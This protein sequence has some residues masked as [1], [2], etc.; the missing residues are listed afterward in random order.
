[1]MRTLWTWHLAS[2]TDKRQVMTIC[3]CDIIV[4]HFLHVVP[5]I[6][7][8]QAQSQREHYADAET[9]LHLPGAVQA[10]NFCPRYAILPQN[11]LLIS[12]L[13]FFCC[14]GPLSDL[15]L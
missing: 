6:H 13:L 9:G 1:M 11:D 7:V 12:F 4:S 14:M 2:L 5:G 8:W 10:L 15:Q 3:P